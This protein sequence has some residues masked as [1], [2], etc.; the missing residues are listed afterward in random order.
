MK[1]IACKKYGGP[2]ELSYESLA[3]PAPGPEEVLIEIRSTA[4]NDFDWSLVTGKPAIYRLLFGLSKPKTPIPGIEMAGTV[5]EVGERVEK[6]QVGDRVYG[7]I[8]EKGWGTFAEFLTIPASVVRLIPSDMT[9]SEAASLPHAANLA[10]QGL[11]D[12]GALRKGQDILINGAGGGVGMLAF[13]MARLEDAIITGVDTGEKLNKMRALG[14]DQVIDYRKTDFTRN[15]QQYDLILDCKTTRSPFAYTRALK[16]G[17]RYV[18]IGGY[19]RKLIQVAVLQWLVRKT[20]GKTVQ[21]LAL[22]P[23][24]N[25]EE[26]EAYFAKGQLRPVIDGPHSFDKIPSLLR[27]F[28]EGRHTGKIV[29]THDS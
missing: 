5:V 14:Y 9:F 2:E 1:A 6:F 27:Y 3:K 18:T 8:S 25:L 21:I 7:D 13:Q 16:P 29:V 12:L 20:T 4:I 19:V 26:I 17:G 24:E 11:F 28:G 15:N 10:Y 22:K 23:N